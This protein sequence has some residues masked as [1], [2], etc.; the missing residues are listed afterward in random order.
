[1]RESGNKGFSLLELIIVIAIMAVLVGFIVPQYMK[2]VNKSKLAN[3]KQVITA[4]HNALAAAILDENI[5]DRPLSGVSP[6]DI[7]QLD[8]PGGGFYS[9]HTDFVDTFKSFVQVAS[10]SDLKGHLKSKEYKGQDILI[11]INGTTQQ[12]KVT[13]EGK[14]GADDFVVE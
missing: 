3:D 14:D 7:E 10:T 2:Y 5:A 6:I 9:S 4:I 12:V 11:E 13:V 8:D 1:M